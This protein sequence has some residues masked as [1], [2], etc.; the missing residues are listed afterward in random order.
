MAEKVVE[1]NATPPETEKAQE[2]TESP[3]VN[4]DAPAQ[5]DKKEET[6]PE[7]AAGASEKSKQSNFFSKIKKQMSFKNINILKKKKS[8]KEPI[9]EK[10]EQPTVDSAKE[11]DKSKEEKAVDDKTTEKSPEESTDKKET[12]VKDSASSQPQEVKKEEEKSPATAESTTKPADV[13]VEV[14]EEKVDTVTKEEKKV[15]E[16]PT[17]EVKPE[18][19]PEV[20]VEISPATDE[21]LDES[22]E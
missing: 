18:V 1:N 15:E 7:S 22:P 11:E 4:G 21:K 12:K 5:A 2:K 10:S 19:K 16:N 14:K 17:T 6:W 8:P 20:K 9:E 3:I 13:K